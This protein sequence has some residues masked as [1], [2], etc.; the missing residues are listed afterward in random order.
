MKH[1]ILKSG[2][3]RLSNSENATDS[4]LS[5]IKFVK[6]IFTKFGITFTDPCCPLTDIQPIRYDSASG[7][8]QSFNGTSWTDLGTLNAL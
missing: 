1:P 3:F 5:L 4:E 2:N 8:I 7:I 6:R